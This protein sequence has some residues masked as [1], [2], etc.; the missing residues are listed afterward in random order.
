VEG[1]FTNEEYQQLLERITA[2]EKENKRLK[3]ELSNK[4]DDLY[5]DLFEEAI[6]GIIFWQGNGEVVKANRSAAKIFE[7]SQNELIGKRLSDF[8]YEKNERYYNIVSELVSTG[9]IRDEL[10]FLMPN[11]QRKLLEFT[12]KINKN[13]LNIMILRNVTERFKMERKL[14]KSEQKFRKIFDGSLEGIILWDEDFHILDVNQAGIDMIG[15]SKDELVGKSLEA[16]LSEY[17]VSKEKL[18]HYIK[19]LE[20]NGQIRGTLSTKDHETKQKHFEFSTKSNLIPGLNLSVFRD[21]TE[22][23]EMEE[24]LRKSDTLNVIGE[25]AAGIAHE[26]RNPMTA[27]KGFIQLL[28]GSIKEDYSMYFHVISTELQRIDSIINEFLILAK[29]Q[30]VKFVESDL[31]KIVRETVELLNAQAVLHNVQIKTYYENDLPLLFCEPNQLKK[32]FINIIKNAIE[33]MPD[34]GCITVSVKKTADDKIHISVEDKGPGIS[35]EK[36]KKLGEPFFTT[37][38]RGTGLGLMVSYKIVEEHNGII[39]VQ[40]EEGKGTTFHIYFP[41][42][43]GGEG[44]NL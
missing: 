12:A 8:V 23:L 20:K 25:L 38:E 13:R 3:E 40:S 5:I 34:G 7:C 15:H 17:N 6:D 14:R 22:K 10:F 31:A 42:K 21:I 43:K 30:A 26:I 16:L 1:A 24:Q 35:E 2:L 9:A 28:Q 44:K 27:L 33:V 18:N 19:K 11:G 36:I 41:I 37:K 32:V 4:N 29:P 39:E